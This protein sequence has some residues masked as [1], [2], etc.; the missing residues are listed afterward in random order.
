MR[1]KGLPDK[2]TRI[3]FDEDGREYIQCTRTGDVLVQTG[4]DEWSHFAS[5]REWRRKTAA[6]LYPE[7]IYL[8]RAL[9]RVG[10]HEE[11]E[12][13]IR[14]LREALSLAEGLRE[15]IDSRIRALGTGAAKRPVLLS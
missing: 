3:G 9:K 13:Q 6:Q 11:V 1:H 4:D 5:S 14:V 12:E 7:L 8:Q 15:T 2:F 10:S